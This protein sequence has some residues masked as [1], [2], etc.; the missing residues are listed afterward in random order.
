ML[1]SHSI[2]NPYHPYRLL[3]DFILSSTEYNFISLGLVAISVLIYM[4]RKYPTYYFARSFDFNFEDGV[5]FMK[6]HI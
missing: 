5:F 4:D 6:S 2:V 3:G 1:N